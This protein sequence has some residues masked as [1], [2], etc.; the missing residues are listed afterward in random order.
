M[1]ALKKAYANI[2][3]NT[4]KE[5]AARIMASERRAV[6]FQQELASAKD[7]ALR[8]L[9]RL[10]QMIDAKVSFAAELFLMFFIVCM[11]YQFLLK[12]IQTRFLWESFTVYCLSL[13]AL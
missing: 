2:I 12:L 8:M 10:K 11:D 6:Q 1:L 7:E 3:L 5:A 13:P 4:G 9:V